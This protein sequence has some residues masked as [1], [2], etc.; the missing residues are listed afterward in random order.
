M[1]VRLKNIMN[2]ST[3]P[4]ALLVIIS[5][6]GAINTI[7]ALHLVPEDGTFERFSVTSYGKDIELAREQIGAVIL[8]IKDDE[9][10][11]SFFE[12]VQTRIRKLHKIFSGH[13]ASAATDR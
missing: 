9:T 11:D 8:Y 1:L 5:K 4:S 13:Q 2:P 12:D 3:T 6:F 10:V 7:N